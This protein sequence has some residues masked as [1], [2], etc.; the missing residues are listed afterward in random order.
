MEKLDLKHILQ[1]VIQ[2][3]KIEILNYKCDYVGIQYAKSNGY[4]F[5]NN[6]LHITYEGG[7]TGKSLKSCKLILK[8]LSDLLKFKELFDVV[9]TVKQFQISEKGFYSLNYSQFYDYKKLPYEIVEVLTRNQFDIFG[10]IEKG[11]AIDANTLNKKT[12][13]IPYINEL[14]CSERLKN[15]LNELMHGIP[16]GKLDNVLRI[17]TKE[18]IRNTRGMGEKSMKELDELRIKY[19]LKYK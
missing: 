15:V 3:V 8:P 18:R 7:S 2:G 11:L 10:L 6:E 12:E 1:H 4:Y 5:L 9:S 19:N 17:F 16:N 13:L 14:N